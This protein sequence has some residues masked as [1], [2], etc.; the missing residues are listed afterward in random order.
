MQKEKKKKEI[1]TG[2]E[3]QLYEVATERTLQK[4]N[5]VGKELP[6]LKLKFRNCLGSVHANPADRPL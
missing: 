3:E 2:N 4:H 1:V 6:V 5:G